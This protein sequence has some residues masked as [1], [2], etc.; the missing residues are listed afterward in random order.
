PPMR[1]QLLPPSTVRNTCPCAELITIR[2]F[3]LPLLSAVGTIGD[4]AKLNAGAEGQLAGSGVK[5]GWFASKRPVVRLRWVSPGGGVTRKK[6]RVS[7][8]MK[9]SKG[10]FV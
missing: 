10:Q 4:T 5:P 2:W 8:P 3:G 1:N 6:L 7:L 9:L